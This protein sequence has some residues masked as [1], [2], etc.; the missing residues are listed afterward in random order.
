LKNL[1]DVTYYIKLATDILFVKNPVS[2]SMGTLSGVVLHGLF[3]L[4]SP[5]FQSFEILK[6]SAITVFH[7]IAI[8]IFGFNIPSYINRHKVSPKVEAAMRLIKE[9]LRE[10]TIS[11]AEANRQYKEL[12]SKVVEDAKVNDEQNEPISSGK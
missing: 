3:G 10:Q 12:I 11:K 2:T 7:F 6:M 8:G 9:Q 4:F 1:N 5:F